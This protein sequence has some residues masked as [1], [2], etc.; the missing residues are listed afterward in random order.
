M[1]STAPN[2]RSLHAARPVRARFES[3]G[4]RPTDRYEDNRSVGRFSSQTED[5]SSPTVVIAIA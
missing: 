1:R 5:Q 4:P 2:S 3:L